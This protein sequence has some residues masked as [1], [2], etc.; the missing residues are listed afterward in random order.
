MFH[1]WWIVATVFMA[2]LF[3]VGFMSY[4]YG[5]LIVEVEKE[6]ACGMEKMNAGAMAM[7]SGPSSIAG[8]YGGS[9]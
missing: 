4:G 7:T 5:L 1:G 3:M 8:P 9:C 6:F 2:Q